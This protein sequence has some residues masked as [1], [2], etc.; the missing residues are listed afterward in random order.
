MRMLPKVNILLFSQNTPES[1]LIEAVGNTSKNA[2]GVVCLSPHKLFDKEIESLQSK[3]SKRLRFFS[4][5]EFINQE[6]MEFC[7]RQADEFI[8]EK[9]KS[10]AHRKND[11]YHKIT[12]IKNEIILKNVQGQFQVVHGYL[13]ADDLGIDA[14][15]WID[16][17]FEV[18]YRTLPGQ[19][20]KYLLK[21]ETVLKKILRKLKSYTT[22]KLLITPER[23]YYFFGR[24][25]RILQYLDMD[26][27]EFRKLGAF[28]HYILNLMSKACSFR[29]E[30][31]F[32]EGFFSLLY[33]LFFII[34]KLIKSKDEPYPILSPIHPDSDK[35]GI[36]A[37]RLGVGMIYMQDGFLPGYYP[38]AYLKYRVCATKYYVWDR[39]S[40]GIFERHNLQCE[41]W[42]YFKSTRLP[43]IKERTFRVKNIVMLTS[44]AGD[45]TAL[46]NRSDEDLAFI[47][48]V[49]VARKLPQVKITYRPH[50]GWISPKHQ[51]VNSINR[52]ISYAEKLGL[53]N[54]VVSNGALKEGTRCLQNQQYHISPTTITD[55]INGADIVFGD[56]S[57]AMLTAAKKGK[58]IASVSLTR[59][60]EFFSDYTNLGFPILRSTDEIINLVKSLE[61]SSQAI[62]KYNRAVNLYNSQHTK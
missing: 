51:G 8:L 14:R 16:H 44:G 36:L 49:D 22:V 38:S 31:R 17:G 25:D 27:I 1:V 28:K 13:L 30:N 56:H 42:P 39:L 35:V 11:Y 33:S 50:P 61:T 59:R 19:Y 3:V 5:Y 4:F 10:R 57:Q 23:T 29:T 47:A 26:K 53:E 34:Y 6:E 37:R 58:I 45:W 21:R 18:R 41:V 54:L 32:V 60:C 40:R 24:T 7:D 48:L 55:E 52:L 46:K 12:E 20:E 62:K 15:V 9:Y 2:F 43:V